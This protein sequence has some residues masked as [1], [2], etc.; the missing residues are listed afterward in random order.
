[1][2]RHT[3]PSHF[4]HVHPRL[5]PSVGFNNQASIRN[6]PTQSDMSCMSILV[7]MCNHAAANRHRPNMHKGPTPTTML[8]A[9]S[10]SDL[11]GRGLNLGC[12]R[13][14]GQGPCKG[15]FRIR[16]W[17]QGSDLGGRGLARAGSGSDLGRERKWLALE[18]RLAGVCA[19]WKTGRRTRLCR[20]VT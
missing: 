20:W 14:W 8:R 5:M 13:A 4:H 1:M 10:G 12:C 3:C 18:N 6:R 2:L 15:R 9:S 7:A 16:S 19:G 11:G 17:G